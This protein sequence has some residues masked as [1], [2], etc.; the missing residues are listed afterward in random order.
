MYTE[1]PI[2]QATHSIHAVFC[3]YRPMCSQFALSVQCVL[4]HAVTRHG[5]RSNLISSMIRPL[6]DF[7]DVHEWF[8]SDLGVVHSVGQIEVTPMIPWQPYLQNSNGIRCIVCTM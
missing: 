5:Q 7:G 4:S 2:Q 8:L 3:L 1:Q 6:G